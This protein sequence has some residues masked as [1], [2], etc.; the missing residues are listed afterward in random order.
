MTR[1]KRL[2]LVIFTI[3][4]SF[5]DSHISLIQ[6][7]AILSWTRIH[8]LSKIILFSN[9]RSVEQFAKKH[10]LE[11]YPIKANVRGTPYV[12][13]SFAKIQ[14]MSNNRHFLYLNSDIILTPDFG[15][16]I[17]HLPPT[18][19]LI[20]GR[21][22]DLDLDRLIDFRPRNWWQ[23]FSA[24]GAGH[25][26]P[27]PKLGS[28][29]F[30]FSRGAIGV[31]PEFLVGRIGWDNWLISHAIRRQILA[32]D[33]SDFI[34]ALHQ[35]HEYSHLTRSDAIAEDPESQTNMR[36]ISPEDQS[37]VLDDLPFY[38]TRGLKIERR[39]GNLVRKNNLIPKILGLFII[40]PLL[41]RIYQAMPGVILVFEEFR[42]IIATRQLDPD[43]QMVKYRGETYIP[44]KF[45]NEYT[46][47]NAK[48]IYQHGLPG[49]LNNI[50]AAYHLYPRKL[51]VYETE[52]EL[53]RYL[54]LAK[55]DL[56][57]PYYVFFYDSKF[58][59]TLASEMVI[60]FGQKL[61]DPITVFPETSFNS[62]D[63]RYI[64][65]SGIIQIK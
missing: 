47:S 19:Y 32:I 58:P 2:E 31:M 6:T 30:L 10:K 56:K 28:D 22:H 24:M 60:V 7:N 34:Y 62:S 49:E 20:C 59:G 11:C 52:E 43:Q 27:H 48:I 41:L 61:D 18:D 12:S 1:R 16:L 36:N 53:D 38:L 9:D 8:P 55:S 65:R 54:M 29:Y 44:L 23:N 5:S 13:E 14:R 50:L 4:K 37:V 63:P 21:R 33:G 17:R 64:N 42:T 46:E 51:L 35:N 25:I 3:P 39:N 26:K 57:S 40:F 45:I 15:K